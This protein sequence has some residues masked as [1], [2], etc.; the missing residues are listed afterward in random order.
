M[1]GLYIKLERE[2]PE[3]DSYVAGKALAKAEPEMLA[4]L[5]EFFSIGP[6]EIALA[7]DE[8]LEI[9]G[10]EQ[11]WFSAADG[12]AIVRAIAAKIRADAS[13]DAAVKMLFD[14]SE[15]ERVL[16]RAEQEKVGW[17]LGVDY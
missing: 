3:F 17:S 13:N 9:G 4:P 8:G 11:K 14:F 12:L 7:E 16:V 6:E 10:P 1:A 2:I 15:F 5:M